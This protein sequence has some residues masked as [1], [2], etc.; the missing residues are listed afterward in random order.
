MVTRVASVET[1]EAAVE[2]PEAAVSSGSRGSLESLGSLESPGNPERPVSH[3]NP[4]NKIKAGMNYGVFMIA[5][6][7]S[8]QYKRN[9]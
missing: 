1:G 4:R 9:V 3:G 2:A 7:V 6:S 8:P 5:G